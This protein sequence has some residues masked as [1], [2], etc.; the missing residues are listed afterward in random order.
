MFYVDPAWVGKIQGDIRSGDD[1]EFFEILQ[2]VCNAPKL[3]NRLTWLYG[4][5][6]A[7]DAPVL[8]REIA[9]TEVFGELFNTLE[10]RRRIQPLDSDRISVAAE[11]I[12]DNWNRKLRLSEICQASDLSASYLIRAFKRQFGMTPYAYLINRRIQKA[13]RMLRDGA[14]IVDVAHDTMFY[15]QAHF[16]RAFKRFTAVNPGQFAM[17]FS[18]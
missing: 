9:A 4:A 15:D 18:N 3:Y 8:S 11:F 2:T 17:S 16:Q 7:C 13:R 6:T 5:L 14:N 1:G 12:K 10:G